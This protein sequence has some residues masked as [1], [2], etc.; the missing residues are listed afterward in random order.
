V[1]LTVQPYLA[2]KLRILWRY[3]FR[4]YHVLEITC[5]LRNTKG[6]LFH[7]LCVFRL[8]LEADE[9]C[10]LLSCYAAYSSGSLPNVGPIF[11]GREIKYLNFF[12]PEEGGGRI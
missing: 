4:Q 10:A 11:K 12:T 7:G 8:L 2:P 5:F 3:T 6:L 9:I 1:V